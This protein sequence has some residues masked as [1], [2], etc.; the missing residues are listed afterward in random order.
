MGGKM[1]KYIGVSAV[2]AA[3]C[4]TFAYSQTKPWTNT[5][6]GTTPSI[7][8]NADGAIAWE[9]NLPEALEKAREKG[10][11]VMAVFY[12]DWC[13]WCQKLR[14]EVFTTAEVVKRS[15]NF[16]NVMINT[17]TDTVNAKR[18]AVQGLPTVL[19]MGPNGEVVQQFT[20]YRPPADFTRAMREVL[21][22]AGR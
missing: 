11:P 18:Y 14:R 17:D 10:L 2:I 7:V 16:V 21:E 13:S 3:L 19:F 6:T 8:R 20:G 1:H 12:A 22:D 5:S 4:T 9:T 15:K